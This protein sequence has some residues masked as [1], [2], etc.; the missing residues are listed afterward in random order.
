MKRI[1]SL[2]CVLC[3]M[4]LAI[5]GVLLRGVVSAEIEKAESKFDV[6]AAYLVD[7]ESGQVLYEQNARE[8][9]P[10]ASMV[11]LMTILLTFEEIDAGRLSLDDKITT[12]ENAAGMGGSQVFIDP[13]VDYRCEDLLKSVVVASANDASVAL[14]EKIAGTEEDF[15]VRMNQRAKELGMLDTNY[16]NCTGLPAAGQYSCAKDIA[17]LDRVVIS[18]KDY[19]NYSTIW[20]EDLVHPSGRKTGLVNTNKLIRY[21]KGCDC[22]KTGSTSEAGYCLTASAKRGDM[23]LVGTIIGAKDSKSRFNETSKLLNFGFSNFT[24]KKIVDSNEI[25]GELKVKKSPTKIV[26]VCA[27]KDYYAITKKGGNTVYEIKLEMP[28]V[29]SAPI[30]ATQTV[31]KILIIKDNEVV[32]E[33]P[34][35]SRDCAEKSNYSDALGE[36][37]KNWSFWG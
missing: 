28:E 24:N 6:K 37:V 13:H 7:Y 1:L 2:C 25:L 22:G 29:V 36:V 33:I 32:D 23:R 20:M 30:R 5:S 17:T 3:F 16:V 8:H 4:T 21:F 11:K 27:Q 18:H 31:G 9:L 35:I 12:S 14:A 15:V 34:L 10:V 26:Q 19:F